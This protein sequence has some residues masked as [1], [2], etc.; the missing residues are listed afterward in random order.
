MVP[1]TLSVTWMVKLIIRPFA[2]GGLAI[3]LKQ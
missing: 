3:S 2:E 1:A